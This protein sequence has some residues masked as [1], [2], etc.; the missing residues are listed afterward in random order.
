MKNNKETRIFSIKELRA[1]TNDA[2][3]RFIEGYAAKYNQESRL[4]WDYDGE[5][6]EIIRSGAFRNVLENAET[7]VFL[8]I[9]HDFDRIIARFPSGKLQLS[10]DEVGLRFS[11]EIPNNVTYVDDVYNLIDQG[12]M[13]E[14]SFMFV[15]SDEN[16]KWSKRDDGIYVREIFEIDELYD[17]SVVYKGAYPNTEVAKRC[18]NDWCETRKDGEKDDKDEDEKDETQ[19]VDYQNDKDYLHLLSL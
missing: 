13:D 11:A 9:N 14:A 16:Q 6:V 5:F 18:Y 7:D 8:T 17:V 3:Q 12:L 1:F 2:G 19:N 15:V 10:E 4:L